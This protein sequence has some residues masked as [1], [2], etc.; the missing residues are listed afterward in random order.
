MN[1]GRFDEHPMPETTRTSWGAIFSSTMSSF[2]RFQDA[3]IA[4]A[5]TPV[6]DR[7]RSLEG[8]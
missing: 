4:A 3:E 8:S 6:A 1:P 5:G 7:T 2:E